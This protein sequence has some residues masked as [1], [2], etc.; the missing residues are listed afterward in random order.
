MKYEINPNTKCACSNPRHHAKWILN[1]KGILKCI[2]SI[3]K[4]GDM[5]KLSKDA[6]DF[7]H[8]LSGF[9]AHFNQRGFIDYYAN[10]ADF[11]AD[12]ENS[13]EIANPNY[14]T[15]DIFSQD[16]QSEYYATKSRILKGIKVLLDEY[17]LKIQSDE[18]ILIKVKMSLLENAVTKCKG[19]KDAEK[20]LL[21][22]L[23][24]I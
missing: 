5:A 17:K 10:V 2:E 7:I 22:Q 1:E 13:S 24:L 12:L 3:F 20:Q 8:I 19:N 9:I 23:N 6:Y 15:N 16:E 11:M 21:K 4:S 18:G 14:Y